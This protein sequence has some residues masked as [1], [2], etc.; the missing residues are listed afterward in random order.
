MD[1]GTTTSDF[2]P[3]EVKRKVSINAS[4]A[5]VEWKDHKV[6]IIDAPGYA[7]FIGDAYSGLAAADT[8]VIV[9]CAASGVQ[10]GTELA[11]QMAERRGLPKAI[12]INRIDREN[13]N[14]EETLQQVQAQLSRHCVPVQ[15][16]IGSQDTFQG[17]VGLISKKA[18]LGEKA[19]EADAPAD[20]AG[21]IETLRAQ[22]M[23]A[24][25]E[26]DE[27]LLDKY[28]EDG[29]LSEDEIR[30][31]LA[32]GMKSGDVVPVFVGSAAKTTGVSRFLDAANDYF[33]TPAEAKVEVAEGGEIS[34]DANGPL[35]AQV[36][37]TT[38][39]PYVGKLT[40]LRV[41]SGTLKADSHAWNANHSAD[42]RIGQLFVVR[43][44]TQ[45]PTQQLVAGDIGAVAKLAE[46]LTGD[47]LTTREKPIK[48][49]PIHFPEPIFSVA[50]FPSRRPTRTR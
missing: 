44:K 4:I 20:L 19:T 12:F 11:W 1:D 10:V 14:F 23:E 45:E 13:A 6:N 43:G 35:A 27:E 48:L 8:A 9:V 32:A 21:Q 31:G 2:D 17:V 28:L 29:E 37:K 46:T 36:F 50:V 41:F 5:P 38:A 30:K 26:T 33:P 7:D 40:Y 34:A 18:Y 16:P 39:D 15:L 25:A 47:T 49:A 42:E 24:V 22:L 3:D